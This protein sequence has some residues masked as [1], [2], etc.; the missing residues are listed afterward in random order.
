MPKHNPDT[1]AI[2]EEIMREARRIARWIVAA[3]Q[4]R[5]TEDVEDWIA[6][7]I[8]RALMARDQR[9]ADIAREQGRVDW[10]DGDSTHYA[11]GYENAC[12]EVTIGILTYSDKEPS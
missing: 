2:P 10:E 3:F 11:H 6:K 9:A 5:E 1:A 4:I 8:A 7:P 12:E